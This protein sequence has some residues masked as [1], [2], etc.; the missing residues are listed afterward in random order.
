MKTAIRLAAFLLTLG[1]ILSACSFNQKGHVPSA[2]EILG[3]WQTVAGADASDYYFSA[4]ADDV[5]YFNTTLTGRPYESG[6]YTING[7]KLLLF[8]NENNTYECSALLIKGN[9]L[10][11]VQDGT[12]VVLRGSDRSRRCNPVFRFLR[13]RSG[14]VFSG[15]LTTTFPWLLPGGDQVDVDGFEMTATVPVD[16]DFTAV[17]QTAGAIGSALVKMGFSADQLNVTEAMNGYRQNELV[18]QIFLQETPDNQAVIIVRCGLR[19]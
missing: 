4:G 8:A 18:C 16:G 3:E 5:H 12:A 14:L 2:D 19:K 15:P 10:R 11:Y 7:D 1:V 17:N 6:T 13:K 9:A